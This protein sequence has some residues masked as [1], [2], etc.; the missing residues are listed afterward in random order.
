MTEK[1]TGKGADKQPFFTV[2]T[3]I[4]NLD[5]ELAEEIL[6]TPFKVTWPKWPRHTPELSRD[7]WIYINFAEKENQYPYKIEYQGKEFSNNPTDTLIVRVSPKDGD[8]GV[9]VKY[10][11]EEGTDGEKILA[12]YLGDKKYIHPFP[13]AK[14]LEG[15][16]LE[17]QDIQETIGNVAPDKDFE[18]IQCFVPEGPLGAHEE[19]QDGTWIKV[20]SALQR[21]TLGLTERDRLE[22]SRDHPGQGLMFDKGS[23][24]RGAICVEA[25]GLDFT[26]GQYRAR[27][28]V[29]KIFNKTGYLGNQEPDM[30]PA[31]PWGYRGELPCVITTKSEYFEAYGVTKFESGRGKM[32]YSAEES[33]LAIKH[34]RDLQNPVTLLAW[35]PDE[36]GG[37]KYARKITVPIIS[38]LSEDYKSL[39]P[40]ELEQFR[41]R[42]GLG[43]REGVLRIVAGIPLVYGLDNFFM[44]LPAG[45]LDEIAE[46]IPRA[47]KYFHNFI[48]LLFLHATAT[49]K[50]KTVPP[51]DMG[52]STLA[53]RLRMYPLIRSGQKRRIKTDIEKICKD[54]V[55]VGY[56]TDYRFEWGRSINEEKIIATINPGKVLP[57]PRKITTEGP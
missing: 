43:S 32:E 24:E 6:R 38:L 45:Y 55:E 42:G 30:A 20:P 5:K 17:V 37:A 2:L 40:E 23:T 25:L 4:G 48:T 51:L 18:T 50:T 34:L 31:N 1:K 39:S 33:R 41:Q 9:S 47:G 36:R 16:L 29:Q 8:I 49:Y 14:A 11:V 13:K 56:I 28:A 53:A 21:N 22:L 7:S 44:Q 12:C 57:G 27:F 15:K 46:K 35:E 10:S 26:G 19:Y 3:D 54:A 52:L